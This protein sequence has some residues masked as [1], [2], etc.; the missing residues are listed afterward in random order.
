MKKQLAKLMI[1]T[2]VLAFCF[3]SRNAY[4]YDSYLDEYY[5]GHFSIKD[6]A[7]DVKLYYI[8]A[9]WFPNDTSQ[10]LC[11][12][13][14]SAVYM[15]YSRYAE[16]NV[17]PLIADHKNQGFSILYDLTVDEAIAVISYKNGITKKYMLRE[18]ESHGVNNGV[19]ICDSN[20]NIA[21][22]KYPSDWIAAYT[23]N[24]TGWQDVTLTFWEP[25]YE[26]KVN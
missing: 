8:P 26:T 14:D 23:C 19:N 9:D 7:V 15:D 25:I 1:V 21:Y 16:E 3:T 20:G 24:P 5:I 6:T 17:L 12:L 22:F 4:A 11:N 13:E 2:I 10:Y 18:K